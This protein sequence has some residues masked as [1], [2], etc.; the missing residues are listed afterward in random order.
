MGSARHTGKSQ[1]QSPSLPEPCGQGVWHGHWGWRQSGGFARGHQWLLKLTSRAHTHCTLPLSAPS[2]RSIYCAHR[3]PGFNQP[4]HDPH[5]SSG[6]P[7]T[8]GCSRPS[9]QESGSSAKTSRPQSRLRFEPVH[10]SLPHKTPTA[11]TPVPPGITLAR[12]F[13]TSSQTQQVVFQLCSLK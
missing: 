12:L 10:P 9:P 1:P 13:P 6:Q 5:L 2:L 3:Q 8:P 4:F 11:P 7:P